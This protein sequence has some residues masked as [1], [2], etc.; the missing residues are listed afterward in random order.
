MNTAGSVRIGSSK[1]SM[2]VDAEYKTLLST[3]QLLRFQLTNPIDDLLYTGDGYRLDLSVTPRPANSRARFVD[4]WRPYRYERIGALFLLRKGERV[5]AKSDVGE[6]STIVCQLRAEPLRKWF[7]E[8]LE[9]TD[10]RLKASL[11][12]SSESIKTLLFRMGAEVRT[13]RFGHETLLELMAA[14]LA[15]ELRQYC[16][17][18]QDSTAGSALAR[19]RLQLIDER[20]AANEPTPSLAELASL[21][22]MSVRQ[23]TRGFR[24]SRGCS[25]GTCIAERR[26]E[27]AKR[28]LVAG[29]HIQV[30][31][32]TLGFGSPSAFCYAFRMAT[33]S[34]PRAFREANFAL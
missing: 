33:G 10:Q 31:A 22:R 27:Q 23:M 4:R 32:R 19:W 9:W 21:C 25:I 18:V 34:T 16:T 8:E 17:K 30:I 1:G 3:M 12:I 29:Q 2:R 5:H 15:V 13:P 11:D 26:V 14:Q 20:L 7:G 24:I 28:L 6:G